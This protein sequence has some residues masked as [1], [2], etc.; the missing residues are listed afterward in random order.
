MITYTVTVP[1]V[2]T[3][4]MLLQE[5]IMKWNYIF[6]FASGSEHPLPIIRIITSIADAVELIW[7]E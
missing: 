5:I 3:I 1:T 2:S 4:L 7:I 6:I